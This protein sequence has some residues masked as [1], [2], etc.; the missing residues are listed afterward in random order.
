MT[1]KMNDATKN[2]RLYDVNCTADA[3]GMNLW[4]EELL[5]R[6]QDSI[7][8]G[9][10]QSVFRCMNIKDENVLIGAAGR[11]VGMRILVS[12]SA[13]QGELDYHSEP[14]FTITEA[15]E[16][17][18]QSIPFQQIFT[19]CNRLRNKLKDL[20][21]PE[22]YRVPVLGGL[23]SIILSDEPQEIINYYLPEI[24]LF[25]TGNR[26]SLF[27]A[28]YIPEQISLPGEAEKQSH[29]LCPINS[30][31]QCPG[32]D[33][34]MVRM[35]GVLEKLKSDFVQKVVV[36]RKCTV[37][38]CEAFDKLDYTAYLLDQYFQEYFYLFRQGED[39]YWT[40]ISPEIIMKQSGSVAVTKPLAGTRKKCDD[41]AVNQQVRKELTATSKDIIEHE[42]ALYFMVDQLEKAGIGKVNIVKNKTVLETPYAFH[43]KSEISVQLKE[44]VSC[45]DIIGA[46]YPPATIWGI[47]VDRTEHILAETEPFSREYFT[48]LYGYW[49]YAGDA[50]TALVIRSAKVE[51]GT[52]SVY[53]GGGIVKYS[54]PNAEFDETVNK[55]RPLL[56]YFTEK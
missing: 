31:V 13:I 12:R 53:A 18:F 23:K 41:D 15:S 36:A 38:P 46:I 55:M 25:G 17:G 20:V 48:G 16:E 30:K 50:D 10:Y 9:K 19:L 5:H 40:G 35:A 14:V 29:A 27:A 54:D 8:C 45:F 49:N 43:I 56:S 42:H 7:C 24:E 39:A 4:V 34:Y 3:Q 52:V 2:A 26:F 22:F 47:P 11:L 37:T 33:E 6:Y 51:D 21:G 1:L 32:K 44:G 28:G